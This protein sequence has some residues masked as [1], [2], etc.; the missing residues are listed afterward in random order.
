MALSRAKNI[1]VSLK[2]L[3]QGPMAV[4]I[5]EPC[6][7][8]QH[9]IQNGIRFWAM[10]RRKQSGCNESPLMVGALRQKPLRICWRRTSQQ[11]QSAGA[12]PHERAFG[13]SRLPK[14][15]LGM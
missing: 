6:I 10:D 12:Q 9:Q 4:V 5:E 15:P 8:L 1:D 3:P 14:I 7:W 2:A 13:L 11:H